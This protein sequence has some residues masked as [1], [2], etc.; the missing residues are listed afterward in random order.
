MHSVV[1]Y[2][3]LIHFFHP[4]SPHP[5]QCW[6]LATRHQMFVG[7]ALNWGN[8]ARHSFQI[9]W[10]YTSCPI[11]SGKDCNYSQSKF[12][13]IHPQNYKMSPLRDVM[14]AGLAKKYPKNGGVR[15][16]YW[17]RY[18]WSVVYE[19]GFSKKLFSCFRSV[20]QWPKKAQA[21]SRNEDGLWVGLDRTPPMPPTPRTREAQTWPPPFYRPPLMK[22]ICAG[23]PTPYPLSTRRRGGISP[24]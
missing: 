14:L 13:I 19:R 16:A 18:M 21:E 10:N 24:E 2:H 4:P 7:P 12:T 11:V 15:K 6:R 8:G 23:G 3:F 22:W 9:I 1:I 20:W 17:I 5:F